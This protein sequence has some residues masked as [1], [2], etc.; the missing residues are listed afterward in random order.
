MVIQ[1]QVPIWKTK[2]NWFCNASAVDQKVNRRDQIFKLE[3]PK[4]ILFH[5]KEAS[6]ILSTAKSRTDLI[7]KVTDSLKSFN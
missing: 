2:V 4:W 7:L 3:A 6:N 5:L 1:Y